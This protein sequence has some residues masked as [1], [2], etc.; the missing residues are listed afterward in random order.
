MEALAALGFS[1]LVLHAGAHVA[2]VVA[3]ARAQSPA[4]TVLAFLLP[5]VAATWAWE[6][7]ARRRVTFYLTTLALFAAVVVVLT[8]TR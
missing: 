1:L 6:A 7:G 4:R 2:N 8:H 3:C 5:P